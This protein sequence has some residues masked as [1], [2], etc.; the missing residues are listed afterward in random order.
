MQPEERV[1]MASADGHVGAPTMVYKDYLEKRLHG[2]FDDYYERHLW[3][4]SP[5]HEESYFPHG[6]HDKFEGS[7]GFDPAVGT[8]VTWDPSLRLKAYDQVGIACEVLNPDDQSSNDPPFGS[9]LATAAVDGQEYP[10]ELVR[11]GARSY[12][13]WLADFC[14]TNNERLLGLTILGTLNDP[15]W[16]VDEIERAY[17]SGLKTGILLP[18]EYYEPL[19]HH[20]R[21]DIIWQ[22]CVDL[23]LSV[24]VHVSKGTPGWL[25]NDPFVERFMW[26]FEVFWY[27]QR[28]AWCM[29]MGGVL[30]K[31]P[32]LK[33]NFTEL[34]VDWVNPLLSR[35]D[36]NLFSEDNIKM[37]DWHNERR[38]IN[39]S[40]EKPSDYFTR[41]CSVVHSAYQLH[42]ELTGDLYG[43]IPN[44][45]WGGDVGH[46]EGLWPTEDFAE[47]RK[48]MAGV[49][50]T[51][52]LIRG[53]PESEALAYLRDN[54]FKF[55]PSVDRKRQQA[56]AD[57]IGPTAAQLGIR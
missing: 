56:V 26:G 57:E 45:V 14:S 46:G 18:L 51:A 10:P 35:L 27:G 39:Y 53:L 44:L 37:N 8:A 52:A 22:T 47:G 21:Y 49:D 23:N 4:W 54:F 16:C 32:D 29:I 11:A 19:Y 55:Y 5:A 48:G 15:V 33:V 36:K 40:L 50:A 34:G 20:P 30:E 41:Q 13:R 3:R 9:G 7:E 12:N 24:E 6:Y 17:N 43:K 25:G 28:P 1:L 42:D 31:F 38:S 2:T